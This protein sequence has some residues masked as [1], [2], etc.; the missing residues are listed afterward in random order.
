MG[1]LRIVFCI[2]WLLLLLQLLLLLMLLMMLLLLVLLLLL[3]PPSA[4]FPNS[5]QILWNDQ[6]DAVQI[7]SLYPHQEPPRGGC[8]VS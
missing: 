5:D 3:L 4:T 6:L 8:R 7:H 2:P 1:S